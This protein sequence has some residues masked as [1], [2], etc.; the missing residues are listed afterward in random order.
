MTDASQTLEISPRVGANGDKLLQL[1]LGALGIVILLVVWEFAARQGWL[2]PVIASS[3]SRIAE[4]FVRQWSSGDLLVDLRTS[5]IEFVIGFG[6]AIIIGVALG[7]AMGL[8]RT[9]EYAID[10]FVWFLYSSP[11]IA[12]YP[13]LIVWLGFGFATV[14]AVAFLLSFVSIVVNAMAGVHAVEPGLVRAVLA[15]GGKRRDV[16]LKVILPAS[17]PHILAGARIG[18]GRALHGVVLGE[19]FGSNDGLGYSITRYA[20]QLKTAEVFVPLL[21]L[22]VLGIVIN[23]ASAALENWLLSWRRA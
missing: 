6:L 22:I 10:P 21:T 1:G 8:N 4:A 18:L 17:V 9:L 3:P 7:I 12:F 2:N 16:I 11:L 15:F 23:Q 19:M 13:L 5:A 20:A 14:V